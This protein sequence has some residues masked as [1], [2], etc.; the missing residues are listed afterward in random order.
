MDGWVME[1]MMH[2]LDMEGS[3]DSVAWR[4]AF[5]GIGKEWG[6]NIYPLCICFR[7]YFHVMM[8]YIVRNPIESHDI[9]I[10]LPSLQVS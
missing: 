7:T 4:L 9:N 5:R 10:S 2:E 8:L 1:Y 3:W 6:E